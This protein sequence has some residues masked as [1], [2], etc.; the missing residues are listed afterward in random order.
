[1]DREV[2]A[3]GIPQDAYRVEVDED[4]YSSE[5]MYDREIARMAF[6]M[7]CQAIE[8]ALNTASGHGTLW[9]A[10]YRLLDVLTKAF[11]ATPTELRRPDDGTTEAIVLID[12]VDAAVEDLVTAIQNFDEY[13]A[14]LAASTKTAAAEG[15]G[16]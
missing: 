3:G 1:M 8:L 4:L 13:T 9:A 12:M 14:R 11:V 15:G 6:S 7:A 2:I 5:E 10:Q 16:A